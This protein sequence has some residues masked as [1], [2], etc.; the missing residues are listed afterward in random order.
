MGTKL[1]PLKTA[2]P[3][4]NMGT[5]P[6][7]KPIPNIA[8]QECTHLV[9]FL[10]LVSC[11]RNCNFKRDSKS[12]EITV[13]PSGKFCILSIIKH[14]CMLELHLIL[15]FILHLYFVHVI[16][17]LTQFFLQTGYKIGVFDASR[18]LHGCKWIVEIFLLQ[19]CVSIQ[20]CN[21]TK[22]LNVQLFLFYL[23]QL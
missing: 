14:I 12:T 15:H 13:S 7:T 11:L 1:P 2:I 21:T 4:F 6:L 19:Y 10:F 17:E 20:H 18:R 23:P 5:F 8:V 22:C 9:A 16:L 3:H